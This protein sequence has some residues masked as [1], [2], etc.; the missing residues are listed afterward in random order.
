MREY[1][2]H[3]TGEQDFIIL[4][5]K[6]AALLIEKVRH[7]KTPEITV[8]AEELMGPDYVR[9]LERALGANASP[10]DPPVGRMELYERLARQIEGL[11]VGEHPCFDRVALR[12]ARGGTRFDLEAGR[13]FFL[14][15]KRS[16]SRFVC[17]YP[18]GEEFLL[19][20]E[21]P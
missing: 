10:G 16:D 20:L 11:S 1:S 3:L 17:T 5:P 9:Y 2:I 15:S 14:I 21:Y 6:M 4:S 19:V 13:E 7:A 18:D 12:P 8:P